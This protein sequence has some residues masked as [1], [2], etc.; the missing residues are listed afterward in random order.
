M[1]RCSARA[2]QKNF[3]VKRLMRSWKAVFNEAAAVG[4]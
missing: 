4:R 1:R 3:A 2:S